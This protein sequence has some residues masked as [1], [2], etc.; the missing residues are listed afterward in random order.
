MS[1]WYD[2]QGRPVYTVLRSDGKGQRPT[3]LRDAKKL[4]LDPGVTTIIAVAASPGLEKWKSDQLAYAFLNYPKFHNETS[5]TY[6]KRMFLQSQSL[7]S[8]AAEEGV[9]IHDQLE[10]YFTHKQEVEGV[11][12]FIVPVADFVSGLN[13]DA[14]GWVAER[15]FSHELGFGGKIDILQQEASI[16]IDYKTKDKNREYFETHDMSFDNHAMQLA[17]YREG[18]GMST[19]SCYNIF[20][21]TQ[22]PGLIQVK[23]WSEPELVRAWEM[24]KCLLKYWQVCNRIRT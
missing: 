16:I 7:A 19:A 1:H 2:D 10:M 13:K 22:E 12:S 15:S 6:T 24:F 23:K 9:K 3:T 11:S 5:E 18:A 17:A 20:I 21:S 14:G 4:N 8:K